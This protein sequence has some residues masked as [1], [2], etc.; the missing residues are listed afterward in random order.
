MDGAA[1][2]PASG[3]MSAGKGDPYK[4]GMMQRGNL[5]RFGVPDNSAQFASARS[6]GGSSW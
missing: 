6:T 5:D 2:W 3:F 1:I 4:R